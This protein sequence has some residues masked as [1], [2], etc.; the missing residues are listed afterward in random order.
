MYQKLYIKIF[1]KW[2]KAMTDNT[3]KKKSM[4]ILNATPL[5]LKSAHFKSVRNVHNWLSKE[6]GIN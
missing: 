5:V 6:G 3:K 1:K 2:E 4:E